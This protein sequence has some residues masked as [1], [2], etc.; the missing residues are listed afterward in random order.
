MD[1]DKLMV[2]FKEFLKSEQDKLV[3]TTIDDDYKNFLDAKEDDLEKNFNEKHNFQ[4]NTRGIKIRGSYPTQ[5]E[6]ELTV[7]NVKRN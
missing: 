3:M 1:F 2:D 5:A 4:T 6:A 7:Q